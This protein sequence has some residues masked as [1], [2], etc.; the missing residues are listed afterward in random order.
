MNT[1]S[2]LLT[3]VLLGGCAMGINHNVATINGKP[4]LVETKNY[5]TPILPVA[6]WS[7]EPTFKE[8]GENI[9]EVILRQ[10]INEKAKHCKSKSRIGS[11][12]RNYDFDKFY[13]C[14]TK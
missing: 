4:Y 8:L 10:E 5:V 6:Q 13:E 7:Q 9:D 12:G 2:I 3:A 11:T 1:T 14:L